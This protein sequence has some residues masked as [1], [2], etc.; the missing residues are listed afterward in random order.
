[1]RTLSV[2]DSPIPE[3]WPFD[4]DDPFPDYAQALAEAPVHWSSEL[5]CFLVLGYEQSKEVLFDPRWSTDPDA[6]ET[7]RDRLGGP[8]VSPILQANMAFLDPPEHTRLRRAVHHLFTPSAVKSYRGLIE[9]VVDTTLQYR[10]EEFVEDVARPIPLAVICSLFGADADTA[11]VLQRETPA[12]VNLLNPLAAA[13]AK[14]PVFEAAVSSIAAILPMIADRR[15]NPRDEGQDFLSDLVRTLGRDEAVITA[16]LLLVAGYE[17]TSILLANGTVDLLHHP[18]QLKRLRDDPGLLPSAVEELLRHE[19]PLQ[20]TW[21]AAKADVE[22]GGLQVKAGQF[23]LIVL[24]AANRD[25]AVFTDPHTLDISR[26][27]PSA[28]SFGHGP[29]YCLGVALARMEGEELFG[30]IPFVGQ[31]IVSMSRSRVPMLRRVEHLVL[32]SHI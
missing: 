23:A 1:M 32:E 5:G 3:G 15:A 28:L 10:Y 24:G 31:K 9:S 29:H 18:D 25:P 17:T 11:A 7:M 2:V 20:L 27:G 6:S 26:G 12:L 14:V 8:G 22:I 16:L 13:Q 21:R 30:R 4:L 19:T